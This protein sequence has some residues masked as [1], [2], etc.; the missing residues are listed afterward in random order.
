MA[1]LALPVSSS[2]PNRPGGSSPVSSPNMQNMSFMRKWAARKGSM[3]LCRMPSASLAKRSAASTVIASLVMPGLSE[4]GSVK[5]R[6]RMSRLAGTASPA[7]SKSVDMLGGAGEVRVDLEAVHV[8]D[9]HQR[10]VLQG[11]AV[12]L[13]LPV[14]FL[15]VLVLAL[16]IPSRNDP[17]SKRRPSPSYLRWSAPPSRR[18]TTCRRDRPRPAWAGRAVRTGRESAAGRHCARRGSRAAIWR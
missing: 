9:D 10:R 6:R 17:A 1:G 16:C 8:A 14:G 12:Q 11:L 5:T 15:E 3:P 4:S 7:R 13:Q 2:L 18:C